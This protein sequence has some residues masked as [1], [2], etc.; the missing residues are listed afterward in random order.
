MVET[1]KPFDNWCKVGIDGDAVYALGSET[2][3]SGPRDV[4]TRLR[5]QTPC[6]SCLV[7]I[8]PCPPCPP[9]PY[10]FLA[11]RSSLFHKRSTLGSRG[12]DGRLVSSASPT[13]SW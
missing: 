9:C 4:S 10:T 3:I 6:S 1:A 13:G 7:R 11:S 5:R 12:L 2:R 8:A